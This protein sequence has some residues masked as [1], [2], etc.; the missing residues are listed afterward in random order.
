MGGFI[1]GGRN[2]NAGTVTSVNVSGGT[3]GLTTSGGPVTNAGTIT[4][5]GTLAVADGGTGATSLT[6]HGVVIGQATSAVHVTSAGTAGQVLTSNGASADPTFQ[7]ASGATALSGLSD[8]VENASNLLMGTSAGASLTSGT[9]NTSAGILSL[10]KVTSGIENTALGRRSLQNVVTGSDNTAVGY[11]S[12]TLSTGDYN[13]GIGGTALDT[14]TSG[15][16]NT[17][18][19]YGA[20]HGNTTG[21]SNTALGT[22]AD[23]AS[24]GL[25]N[26]MALGNSALVSSS[27]TVQVGNSSVTALTV[28]D[29]TATINGHLAVANVTGL[30]TN[31]ATF[32]ATPSSANLAAALTDE[33]GT[34]AAVFAN[35]PTLVSPIL[36]TPTS[37]TL[38]NC[39]GLPVAG[40]GTGAST[41]TANNV[42]LG[43][44]TSA[45]Q[46]VAPGSSGNVLTSNGTTWTS[47]A[48][49][50][51]GSELVFITSATASTSA[52]LDFVTQLTGAYSG[53]IFVLDQI[54]PDT[55]QVNLLMRFSNSGSSWNTG[56]N[57]YKWASQAVK[58]DGTT[59]SNGDGSGSSSIQV[60]PGGTGWKLL[61]SSAFT[62]S[63]EVKIYNPADTA[64]KKHITS[65]LSFYGATNASLVNSSGSGSDT[66]GNTAVT[67]VQFF[68]SSGNITSGTI[69]LYGIKNS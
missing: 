35:T 36:G 22:G 54:Y 34:G 64:S 67:G 60:N 42:L 12:L 17:A 47:A 52:S 48:P 37:G 11:L 38:T 53:F 61:S 10:N 41:L 3:T 18:V 2:P 51:G 25:S 32:L 39:T 65:T 8:V 29:G 58:T 57:A 1:G 43:N 13:T 30:G 62:M 24:T 16:F 68:M 15:N 19:G 7:A 27:N 50:G 55:D 40:G 9:S 46:F 56:A 5:G 20:L 59:T 44:G 26:A 21:S 31:V 4:L 45:V 28:G 6:N 69:Y 33:T 14:N 63:G 23:V 49:S 66:T